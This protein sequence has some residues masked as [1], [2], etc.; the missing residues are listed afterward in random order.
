MRKAIR[1]DGAGLYDVLDGPTGD[2]PSTRP[3]QLFAVSL[4]HS[5]LDAD[6]QRTL[7]EVC[8]RELLT[9]Y[10]VRSLT[11][12]H[13]HY[14]PTYLGGVW[15]RDGGYHQGAVWGWLLGHYAL[16]EYRVY[17]DADAAQNRLQP[18]RDHLLDAG[19]GTVSEIFDGV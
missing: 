18:I 11:A 19:L 4:P 2:D 8:G 9:S 14:H 12:D 6:R 13:P 10:G 17:G 7:V 15:E 16:A 5:P 1:P 3:N